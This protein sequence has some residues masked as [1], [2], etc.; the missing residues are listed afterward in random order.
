MEPRGFRVCST[1]LS[2]MLLGRSAREMAL[3]LT[4]TLTI[5]AL[6]TLCVHVRCAICARGEGEASLRFHVFFFSSFPRSRFL[7]LKGG[8]LLLVNEIGPL[9]KQRQGF[10]YFR[11]V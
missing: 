7:D 11:P 5:F 10:G 9:P 1:F 8:V 6:L 4:L 3:N 2:I